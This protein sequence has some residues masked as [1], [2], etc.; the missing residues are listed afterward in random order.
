MHDD[1][2]RRFMHSLNP[3]FV[4]YYFAIATRFT[5]RKAST[6]PGRKVKRFSAKALQGCAS[7]SAARGAGA[8]RRDS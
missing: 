7:P 5:A 1:C 6:K 8:H 3:K 4:S 2:V